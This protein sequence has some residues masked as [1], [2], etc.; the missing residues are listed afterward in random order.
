MVAPK[1]YEAEQ[2]C[3][4]LTYDLVDYV[5]S[6]DMDSLVF[7]AKYI[8]KRNTKT[9]KYYLYDLNKLLIDNNITQDQL[10]DI[11]I[12]LGCDF[13]DKTPK[14]GVKTILKPISKKTLNLLN[15]P[16]NTRRF[17]VITLSNEQYKAKQLFMKEK[18]YGKWLNYKDDEY[19]AFNSKEDI[20]ELLDWLVNINNFNRE[21]IMKAFRNI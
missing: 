10:I 7:G 13:A 12:M 16:K 21:R 17:E 2:I 11:S 14:I 8:I 15:I 6:N 5:L 1:G 18:Q 20:E 9:K 19:C 3:A 4:F